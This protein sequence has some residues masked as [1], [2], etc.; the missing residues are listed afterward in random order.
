MGVLLLH[1]WVVTSHYVFQN[2]KQYQQLHSREECWK[3]EVSLQLTLR[4]SWAFLSIP[5]FLP[6]SPAPAGTSQKGPLS[7]LSCVTESEHSGYPCRCVLALVETEICT[8]S[9][10]Y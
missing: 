2:E 10:G 8:F 4:Q 9:L 5:E 3:N 6:Y 1:F 7:E